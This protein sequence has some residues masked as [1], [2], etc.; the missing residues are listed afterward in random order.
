MTLFRTH[1]V[2]KND[3][4]ALLVTAGDS[5]ETIATWDSLTFMSVFQAINEAFS[6]NPDFDDAIHYTSVKGIYDY[7]KGLAS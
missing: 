5:M 1:F 6:I 4:Q 3:S 2:K 7:I